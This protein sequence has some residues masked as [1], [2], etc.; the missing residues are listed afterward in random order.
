MV[1]L[2]DCMPGAG[3]ATEGCVSSGDST[4]DS[5]S[6]PFAS[7]GSGALRQACNTR[8]YVRQDKT[9]DTR[10]SAGGRVDGTYLNEV[11]AF[12][13]RHQRLELGRSEGIDQSG[14]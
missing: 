14:F 7:L 9:E 4:A 1:G 12:W 3:A 10:Q 6:A 5:P 8:Q 13:F 2:R 11:L